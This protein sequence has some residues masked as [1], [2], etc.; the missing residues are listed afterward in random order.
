MTVVT[1]RTLRL[2]LVPY[3]T[4]DLDPLHR[5]FSNPVVRRFLLDDQEMSRQWVAQEIAGNQVAFEN[6]GLGQ[7]SVR[8]LSTPEEIV[9]FSGFRDF[10][11]PPQLQ[12]LYGLHPGWHGQG[13]A[14]EAARAV[15]RYAFEVAGEDEV[16]AA[17]DPPNTAS[18]SVMKR[19]GM[20]FDRREDTGGRTTLFFR[21][22]KADFDWEAVP[23]WV[24]SSGRTGPL[25]DPRSLPG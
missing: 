19:L 10:F 23:L 25:R 14:T 18:V 21:L 22:A 7:W 6:R 13:L 1:L 12:L 20:R 3:S 9:G 17:T 2:R 11:D 24:E 5:L 16:V 8:L 4:A 15:V